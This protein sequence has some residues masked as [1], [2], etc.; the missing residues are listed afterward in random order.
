MARF[1]RLLSVLVLAVLFASSCG[2]SPKEPPPPHDCL[3]YWGANAG[4]LLP[5]LRTCLGPPDP[6]HPHPPY[7]PGWGHRLNDMATYNALR[8][9][10]Q[11]LATALGEP[12]APKPKEEPGEIGPCPELDEI[13]QLATD[14]RETVGGGLAADQM[15]TAH[16][17]TVGWLKT[18]ADG[19]PNSPVVEQLARDILTALKEA[20]DM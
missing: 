15:S 11:A 5:K 20:L 13:R 6:Q 8:D 4:A 7:G 19:S 16:P 9:L 2:S 3:A 17:P 18:F 10:E 14:M 12:C 1:V